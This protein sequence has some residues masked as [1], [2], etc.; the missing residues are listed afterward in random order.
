MKIA[1]FV[2]YLNGVKTARNGYIACCPAHDD[3]HPSLAITEAEDRLLI[4][5]R[6]GCSPKEVLTAVGLDFEDLY[7]EPRNMAETLYHTGPRHPER[8]PALLLGLAKPM[9]RT[10]KNHSN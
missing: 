1:E 2:P 5:C 7:L 10:G 9:C 6:A 8:C 4:H 3:R